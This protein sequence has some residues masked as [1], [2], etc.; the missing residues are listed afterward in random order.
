[1][2][3]ISGKDIDFSYFFNFFSGK[4]NTVKND[5]LQL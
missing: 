4:S 1:M 3:G 2:T 5:N